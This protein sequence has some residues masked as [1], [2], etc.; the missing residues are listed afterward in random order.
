[1][2]HNVAVQVERD[3]QFALHLQRGMPAEVEMTPLEAVAFALD[4]GT[5]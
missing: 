4:Q 3:A 5:A 2:M 1:M